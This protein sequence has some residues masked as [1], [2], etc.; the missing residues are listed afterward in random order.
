MPFTFSHPAIVL[1]LLRLPRKWVSATGLIVGSMTPDF[2]YFL[3]MRLQGHYGHTIPG[4]FIMDLP[5]AFVLAF[6][7]HNFVRNSLFDNLPLFL[8][9]RFAPFKQFDWNGYFTRYWAAVILSIVIGAGSHL[10]WDGFT[11]VNGFVVREI[12]ILRST[13]HFFGT[14]LAA[15][16]VL[17]HLSTLVGGLAIVY[18]IGILP[19]A[20]SA[21]KSVDVRYWIV[22]VAL[23]LVIIALRIALARD[24]GRLGNV[25]VTAMGALFIS[26]PV[27][28]SI[29]AMLRKRQ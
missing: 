7:F 26:L 28:P 11:H 8:R 18:V 12:P 14:G 4:V 25:L 19:R 3:R 15:C 22:L 20:D 24:M 13:V 23:T 21:A 29:L 16:R 1:P 9:S 10:L 2:E 27:T 17:Q 5:F 6:I